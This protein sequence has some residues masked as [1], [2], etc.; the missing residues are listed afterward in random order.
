V[1]TEAGSH[2]AFCE[3]AL[4]TG[5]YMCRLAMDFLEAAREEEAEAEAGGQGRGGA[6]GGTGGAGAGV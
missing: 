3:G 5:S 1:Q 2:I 6:G 4:G